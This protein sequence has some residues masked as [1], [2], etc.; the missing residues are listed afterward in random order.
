MYRCAIKTRHIAG[1]LLVLAMCLVFYI[2]DPNECRLFP[3]CPFLSLTGWDDPAVQ[4][5]GP[6]ACCTALCRALRYN[7]LLV[8]SIPYIGLLLWAE[9]FR[10]RRP[11]LYLRVHKPIYV[12]GYLVAVILWGVARN[13]FPNL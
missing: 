4:P 1:V 2:L 13:F 12:W 8:L 9:A 10:T 5:T 3:R 6:H 7:A 11:G